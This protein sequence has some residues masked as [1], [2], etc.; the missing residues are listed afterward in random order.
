MANFL[1]WYVF[2]VSAILIACQMDLVGGVDTNLDGVTNMERIGNSSKTSFLCPPE[3]SGCQCNATSVQCINT[4]FTN[5]SFIVHVPLTVQNLVVSGN[6]LTDLPAY[7]FGECANVTYGPKYSALKYLD[8]SGNRIRNIQSKTFHCLPQL[9]TLVLHNNEWKLPHLNHT[10]VFEELTKLRVLNLESALASWNSH[11]SE[12][13]IRLPYVLNKTSTTLEDLNLSNN[14]ILVLTNKTMDMLCD[15]ESLRKL[16]L[17]HNYLNEIP[18]ESCTYSIEQLDLS[19]NDI[20]VGSFITQFNLSMP[21]LTDVKLSHNSYSCNCNLKDFYEWLS[22]YQEKVS[23]V[24]NVTCSRSY[25]DLYQGKQVLSL[26]ESDLKCQ[27]HDGIHLQTS[28]I[29]LVFIICTVLTGLYF[30]RGGIKRVFK[31]CIAPYI[32]SRTHYSYASVEI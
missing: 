7:I 31:R 20:V 1:I 14:D 13:L 22:K 24:D 27:K 23:D 3:L 2:A 8:L 29:I 25:E 17:S 28:Y 9:E 10:G 16:N 18:V 21:F 15:M 6:N 11:E 19:Y 4:G 5:T 26:Q 30:N 12:Y 32:T